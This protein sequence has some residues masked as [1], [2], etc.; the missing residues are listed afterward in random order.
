MQLINLTAMSDPSVPALFSCQTL[1]Q[2]AYS[3]HADVTP[4]HLFFPS[5]YFSHPSPAPLSSP[6]AESV[7]DV[8]SSCSQLKYKR[9]VYKMLKLD[10]RQL[11]AAH[12]RTNLRRIVEHVLQGNADKVAKLCAKGLDPNFHC[13]ETGGEFCGRDSGERV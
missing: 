1:L 11:R 12:S 4:A 6:P 10:E 9:R 13:P 7:S 2:P 3:A 8:A 5:P